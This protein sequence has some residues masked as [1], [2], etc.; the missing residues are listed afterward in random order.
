MSTPLLPKTTFRKAG[1]P[2]ERWHLADADGRIVGRLAARIAMVLMGK[3]RPDY[4][5]H[6]DNGDYVV[7]V[8]CEKV[9]FTGTK[10]DDKVYRRHSGWIGGL[11]EETAARVLARHPDR[12]IRQ[13]VRR[14]LPKTLQGGRML[15]KLKIYAGAGHPHAAQQPGE[16]PLK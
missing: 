1:K 12:I 15:K 11:K 13:A 10:W 14:M 7:V 8:N 9:K 16:F 6:V 2:V 4:T 3:H 5:P